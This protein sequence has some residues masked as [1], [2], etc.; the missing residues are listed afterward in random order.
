[1]DIHTALIKMSVYFDELLDWAGDHLSDDELHEMSE[2]EDTIYQ[3]VG[4][5]PPEE[6]SEYGP[7]LHEYLP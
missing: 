6:D 2:V 1:M 7:A 5:Y 3:Y 4:Q